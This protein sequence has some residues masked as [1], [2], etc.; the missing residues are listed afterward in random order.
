MTLI[1]FSWSE[2]YAPLRT[3]SDHSQQGRHYVIILSNGDGEQID[4]NTSLV[5]F[6]LKIIKKVERRHERRNKLGPLPS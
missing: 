4:G 3:P 5:S 6:E 2:P 1:Q